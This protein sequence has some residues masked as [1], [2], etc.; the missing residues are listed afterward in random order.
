[1]G[2]GSPLAHRLGWHLQALL[3]RLLAIAERNAVMNA[4]KPPKLRGSLQAPR[5]HPEMHPW[6]CLDR[7]I[8]DFGAFFM[9]HGMGAFARR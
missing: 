2:T 1:M 3:T 4:P 8:P 7:E 6:R 9:H 5:G